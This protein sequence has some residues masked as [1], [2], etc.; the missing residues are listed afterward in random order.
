MWELAFELRVQPLCFLTQSESEQNVIFYK[1]LLWPL[2]KSPLD[3]KTENR[4]KEIADL[5]PGDF[6]TVRDRYKFYTE[7]GLNHQEFVAL[8]EEARGKKIHGGGNAIGF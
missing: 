4:L 1:K 8:A 3:G 7:R 2:T 6:K 5:S